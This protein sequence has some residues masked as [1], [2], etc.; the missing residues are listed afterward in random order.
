MVSIYQQ[1]DDIDGLKKS[2]DIHGVVIAKQLVSPSVLLPVW[3]KFQS[4]IQLHNWLDSGEVKLE[5]VRT[6]G[7]E[8]VLRELMSMAEVHDIP[9]FI[10]ETPTCG[11]LVDGEVFVQPTIY[12]RIGIPSI[13]DTDYVTTPHQD[14]V[15]NQGSEK[16]L[17]VWLPFCDCGKRESALQFSLGS[18][19]QGVQPIDF[20][21]E[22]GFK[23]DWTN[24]QFEVGDAAI[25]R[26]LTQH[27]APANTSDRFRFSIDFRIQSFD[28]PISE[29]SL[30][31]TY[32]FGLS[33]EELYERAPTIK[34]KFY[35]KEDR[36]LRVVPY[37]HSFDDEY[38][39]RV[40]EKLEAGVTN[41]LDAVKQ[42]AAQSDDVKL[43]I[44][45]KKAIRLTEA[46]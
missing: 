33:W 41:Q 27:S 20:H 34:R 36:R 43:R 3:D 8:I 11:A 39:A 18:H 46:L 22:P 37:D 15:I 23:A 42:I 13:N 24:P 9:H 2:L 45:A 29:A 44:R 38:A 6:T 25:F 40:V 16:T 10:A 7:S 32:L 5:S 30:P 35:W 19:L 31:P 26:A 4:V 12:S 21:L 14:F 28:M 1:A 17:T